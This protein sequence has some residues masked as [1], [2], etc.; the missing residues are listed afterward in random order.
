MPVAATDAEHRGEQIARRLEGRLF[1]TTRVLRASS[2]FAANWDDDISLFIDVVL[3]D[4]DSETWPV[5][6]IVALDFAVLAIADEVG[7]DMPFYVNPSSESAPPDPDDLTLFA[8]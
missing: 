2:Y 7:L 1:G 6:D 5:D 8:E 4:P 3:N